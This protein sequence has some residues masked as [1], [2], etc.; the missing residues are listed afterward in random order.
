[1]VLTQEP[2]PKPGGEAPVPLR[3]WAGK[4]FMRAPASGCIL[5]KARRVEDGGLQMTA[6]KIDVSHESGDAF[7][8]GN[9]K[10]TWLDAAPP[11]GVNR[12]SRQIRVQARA[13]WLWAAR[14]RRTW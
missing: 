6:D 3:A 7:A 10:A 8:H 12:A 9:V 5:R 1:V 13:M 14:G 11:S 4:A 2:S